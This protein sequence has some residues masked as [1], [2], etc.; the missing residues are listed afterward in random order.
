MEELQW[1]VSVQEAG[2]ERCKA[3]GCKLAGHPH[4]H[5]LI[6]DR[7]IPMLASAANSIGRVLERQAE[8]VFS[9]LDEG[10]WA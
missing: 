4:L 10:G 3:A 1:D 5:L 7:E 8:R 2:S 6:A 9:L